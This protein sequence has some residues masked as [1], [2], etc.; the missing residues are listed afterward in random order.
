MAFMERARHLLS[1]SGGEQAPVVGILI[2]VAATAVVLTAGWVL[3][4]LASLV[5]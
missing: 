2:V 5:Y 4:V 1:G 3:A